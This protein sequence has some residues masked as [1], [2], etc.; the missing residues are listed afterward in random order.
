MILSD[1]NPFRNDPMIKFKEEIVDG[2]SYTIVAYMIGNKELWDTP[3]ADETRGI[4]FETD[5][6]KCVSRPFKKFFNVGERADTDPVSVSRDF[7]EC[8]EKRDG[9]MLTPIITDNGNIIFKTKKSFFS[10]V[11]NTAN[12]SIPF[13]VDALSR[14]CLVYYDSTPIWEFTHPDHKIV[15]DYPPRVRWTLL[16]IRDNVSGEYFPYEAVQAIAEIHGCSVIPRLQMTWDEI[17]RSIENDK[18][19]EGYVLLLK[20]GRRAK[21]K[22]AWYLSMHRTMTELRVRDV[23]EAVVNETIDDM[24]SLVASQGKDIAPLEAIENQVAHELQWLRNEVN[25][26]SQSFIGE[27]FKDI[28]LALKGNHLFSLIMSEMRGK[29]PNYIDFWKRNY[30]KTYSL[31]VVYNPSF[32]KDE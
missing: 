28:A 12:L 30:L 32:S 1:L 20:D 24:K 23:A 17:Q 25:V 27:T 19:I 9:S 5:T 21:Y 11:A 14:N 18:G 13:R 15:I 22:T 7:V 26:A 2:K 31:R 10:D 16:A 6:G 29:E 4:T 3:L 8:Y